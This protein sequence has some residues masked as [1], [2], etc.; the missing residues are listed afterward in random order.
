MSVMVPTVER[1]PPRSRRWSTVTT[2]GRCSIASTA[3]RESAGRKPRTKA[4]SVSCSWR[5]ASTAMVSKT[6]E[7]L[8]E[9]ETPVTAVMARLG[10]AMSRCRRLCSWAPETSIHS[11]TF[12]I[13]KVYL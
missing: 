5:R 4:G 3:G 7:D 6:S 9:P 10:T 8:P 2:A 13:F 1:A 12:S 11:V